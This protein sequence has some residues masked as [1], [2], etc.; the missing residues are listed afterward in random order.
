[1]DNTLLTKERPN[2]IKERPG[3]LFNPFE[4]LTPSIIREKAYEKHMHTPPS[5]EEVWTPENFD[6]FYF[7]YYPT[8]V[9]LPHFSSVGLEMHEVYK[10]K[11]RKR[12][13]VAEANL[14]V[15]ERRLR[16]MTDHNDDDDDEFVSKPIPSGNDNSGVDDIDPEIWVPARALQAIEMERQLEPE[17]SDT[18]LA[19]KI[20]KE[21]LPL[22]AVGITHTAKYASDARLRFQAQTYVMDRVLGKVGTSVVTDESPLDELNKQLM[23]LVNAAVADGSI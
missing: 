4:T 18:A 2:H 5:A 15:T 16:K 10:E 9:D 7:D 1:M 3:P 12:L 8:P 21:N 6:D 23:E 11:M 20:M 19:Q 17:I 14:L 22:V 13:A